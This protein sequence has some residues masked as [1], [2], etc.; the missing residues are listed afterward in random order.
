MPKL[1]GGVHL[2][3]AHV[4]ASSVSV[5]SPWPPRLEKPH[6]SR[7]AV[8]IRCLDDKEQLANIHEKRS[9]Q[10][11]Q[12]RN[13]TPLLNFVFLPSLLICVWV[14]LDLQWRCSMYMN[15]TDG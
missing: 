6:G 8:L 11:M 4:V 3:G 14:Q 15:E 10:R 1:H 9:H 7:C 5:A 13:V 12:K 2:E